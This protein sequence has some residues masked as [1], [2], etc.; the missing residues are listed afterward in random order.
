MKNQIL[1]LLLCFPLLGVAQK[2]Y[3]P[4]DNFESY[5]EN[6]GMGDGIYAN[7]SV[8]TSSINTVDT[9]FINNMFISNLT[10][11]EDF[12][13]LVFL[14][15]INN[16]IDSLDFSNNVALVWLSCWSN[17]LTYLNISS[18]TALTM[19]NCSSNQLSNLDVTSNILLLNISC[20]SN[21]LTTLN[22]SQNTII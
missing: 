20:G 18:N 4:D 17:Q 13:A 3:V 10:G 9:L 21:Q 6:Y 5:L 16:Q 1:V 7:D 2:T 8:L 22:I 14:E 12:I 15:C 19:L 11:I